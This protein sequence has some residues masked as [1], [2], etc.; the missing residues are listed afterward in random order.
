MNNAVDNFSRGDGANRRAPGR[1][2]RSTI[3]PTIV[4]DGDDARLVV[5]SPGGSYIPSAVV[6]AIVWTL[7]FGADP[8]AALAAPRVL[9]APSSAE[10]QVEEGIAADALA[11]LRARGYRPVPRPVTERGFG[12]VHMVLVREDGVRIGAADPRREGAAVGY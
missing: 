4:L 3:S 2:P 12:G 11:A 6:H 7:A 5:G 10:V 9:P 1:T 8:A